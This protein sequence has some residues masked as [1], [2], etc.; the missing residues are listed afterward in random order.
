MT[1]VQWARLCAML[2]TLTVIST[3]VTVAAQQ[4]TP[5]R[6]AVDTVV[7]VDTTRNDDGTQVSGLVADAMVSAALGRGL[8]VITR[9]FLQRLGTTREWNAQLW[10][11]ALRYEHGTRRAIR[12]DAGYIPSPVGMANLFI[13]AHTNPTTALPASL[14]T[15]L[16]ALDTNGPRTTL[17]GNVYPL[18]VSATMSTVRWDA[19]AA[20]IDTSPLRA[21]RVFADRSPPNPPRLPTVVVG[22]GLTPIVGVRIG[23][24]V[25]HGLWERAGEGSALSGDRYATIATV[26]TDV[27]YRHTHIQAEWTRDRV[28]V[29]RG[30]ATASGW[31]VQ[32]EQTLAPRWFVAGRAEQMRAPAPATVVPSGQ[33]RQRFNG[34]E[35]TL[36]FRLTPELTLRVS[37]R[38]RRG[39]GRLDT[40]HATAVSLVWWRRWL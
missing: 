36:G 30:T 7:A 3:G 34:S 37:H 38:M 16:P 12:V 6:L 17:L 14:F 4:V 2:S 26:E 21:R 22:G 35:E 1:R 11:A 33:P 18:G 40:D 23:A 39:F 32:G 20:F 9:P 29:S 5:S 24:S 27:A 13:R 25:S 31:F 15:A 8:Q 28:E 19:R 10:I